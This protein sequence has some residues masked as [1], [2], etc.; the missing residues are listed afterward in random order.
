MKSHNKILI[1]VLTMFLSSCD[2]FLTQ[3][4]YEYIG[5]E[6]F[7]STSEQVGQAVTGCYNGLIGI[8]NSGE[9]WFN[10]NRSD[11]STKNHTNNITSNTESFYPSILMV[12]VSNDYVQ[13]YWAKSYDLISRVNLVIHYL[14]VVDDETKKAQY[15][16]EAK[17]LRG[18]CYFNLVRY[19]G[20]IPLVTKPI[21]NGDEAKEIARSSTDLV[22]EQIIQDISDA[23]ELFVSIDGSYSPAYGR[24]NKWAAAALLGKIYLTIGETAKAL[25]T[26]EVVYNGGSFSL[27]DNYADLFIEA[28]ET[29]KASKEIIF[30]VRFESGGLGLGNNFSTKATHNNISDFGDNEIHYTNN[31]YNAYI[32]SSDTATDIRFKVTCT[33]VDIFQ[34]P[35]GAGINVRYC[36]KMAGLVSDGKGGY[37]AGKMSMKNDGGLDWP[38]IRFA[39][40]VLMLAELKGQSGGGLDLLNKVRARSHAPLYTSQSITN[41]FNGDFQKAVLNERRLELAFE[42]KRLFDMLRMGDD[43][44]TAVLYEKYTTE[45]AYKDIYPDVYTYVRQITSGGSID[46]WRLLLPIPLNQILRSNALEQNPGY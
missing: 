2:D 36:P 33:E 25:S 1:I 3:S 17:F 20:G 38:E 29:S 37:V 19:F 5:I 26:L 31:L 46:S 30:P 41:L 21:S 8:L 22:Y 45:P 4:P 23:Y 6:N 9:Y 14:D 35:G 39:D 28:T 27:I 40:V 34:Y 12:D 44:A 11:N 10:E 42:N 15:E 18:W 24:A 16:A 13:N 7:Y 32:T 43:Y